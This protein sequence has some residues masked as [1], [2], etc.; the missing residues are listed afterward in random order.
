MVTCNRTSGLIAITCN[1][2][3]NWGMNEEATWLHRV[4]DAEQRVVGA[5]RA[6]GDAVDD[7]AITL[8][9][10][11]DRGVSWTAMVKALAAHGRQVNLQQLRAASLPRTERVGPRLVPPEEHRK[12]GPKKREGA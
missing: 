11:R 2:C 6:L 12:T 5:R 4:V 9:T 3:D 7:R 8:R 10:A 1:Q